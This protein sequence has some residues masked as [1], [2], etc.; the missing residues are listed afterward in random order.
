MRKLII[1]TCSIISLLFAYQCC[2]LEA[3]QGTGFVREK[4]GIRKIIERN[5]LQ[6]EGHA[7][8][9]KGFYEEALKKYELAMDPSLLNNEGDK[10]I[11]LCGIRD[12]YK[13]QG[14][15]DEA[16]SLNE[17][18]IL[19]MNPEKDEYINASLELKAAIK[20]RNTK[21]NKPIYDYMGYIK[22]KYADA[23]PP[24]GYW[25]G[26]SSYLINDFIHLYDYIH[27][28]DSGI[29]FMDQIIKYHTTHP[30]KNHRSANAKHVREY[31]RVKEAWR[32]D[33]ETGQHD[34]LQDV[35]RTSN[36]ISW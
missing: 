31:T 34:H 5:K 13:R 1:I 30:N 2:L 36:I 28:Y 23:F 21:D 16:L 22:T 25:Q 29:A 7:L 32:L 20:A 14:R 27:D 24:N 26:F 17:K 10:D 15:F 9:R 11:S 18:S 6:H 8:A 33:K 19:P 3:V 4:E 12:I 35:I